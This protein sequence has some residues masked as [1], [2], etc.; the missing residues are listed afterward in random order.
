MQLLPTA[1]MIIYVGAYPFGLLAG[2]SKLF[3]TF[4]PTLFQKL[5]I[6]TVC[7]L[8]YLIMVEYALFWP[9]GRIEGY[10]FMNPLLPLAATV[11]GI[12]ASHEATQDAVA[13]GNAWVP[14][15][16]AP[17]H[18]I[19]MP[20]MLLLYCVTTSIISWCAIT[21]KQ[22]LLLLLAILTWLLPTLFVQHPTPPSW[23][24]QIGH[25]PMMLPETMPAAR[26]TVLIAHEVKQLA[27]QHPE[28]RLIVMPE[29]AWN[30]L[31]LNAVYEIPAFKNLSVPHLIIGSFSLQNRMHCNSLYWLAN[32]QRVE[33]FDKQHA[34]PFIERKPPIIA[35]GQNRI[36]GC[37]VVGAIV[38][39]QF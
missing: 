13:V 7:L 11:P 2:T 5:C 12:H 20:V 9:F 26:G 27:K 1:L 10:M 17:L 3:R 34:V 14:S 18:W 4:K 28:L 36:C 21:H 15:L 16:L 37:G 30:G 19:P 35:G 25:L 38:A 6:W 23:L 8:I 33:R 31:P 39:K 32:G 24:N 29:S 22:F